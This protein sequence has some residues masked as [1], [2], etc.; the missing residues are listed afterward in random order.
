[1]EMK[2]VYVLI[3]L[4]GSG[5]TY[6]G[7][8]LSERLAIPFLR[9]EDIFLKLRSNNLLE[10]QNY[11][12]RGYENVEKEI[13]SLLNGFDEL[14][15]ESTGIAIQFREMISNLKK[16]YDVKLIKID[17]DPELCI[18]RVKSRNR[19]G[20]IPVSDEMLIEINKLSE[21]ISYD[22]DLIFKN[23]NTTDDELIFEF[24]KA[25]GE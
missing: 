12:T 2:T 9:V 25:F 13:R 10:D 11:I 4:K 8:L 7:K 19:S 20:H 14:T 3:G 24:I 23:N 6:T 15:I 5:K 17:T 16:D 18:K 21:S 1:M 22:Y